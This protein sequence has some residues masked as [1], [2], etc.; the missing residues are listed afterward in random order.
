MIDRKRE[1]DAMD[2]QREQWLQHTSLERGNPARVYRG[3][4]FN[5]RNCSESFNT[6][7]TRMLPSAK[8]PDRV[9]PVTN[10]S[11]FGPRHCG[12]VSAVSAVLPS[13]PRDR[14][15]A[16]KITVRRFVVFG[17]IPIVNLKIL[18]YTNLENA[19]DAI[20]C[21]SFCRPLS[22][23]V[24]YP[25]S[26]YRQPPSPACTLRGTSHAPSGRKGMHVQIFASHRK[27]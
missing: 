14:I 4:S 17:V 16:N 6:P 5:P 21:I 18:C 27:P 2:R 22:R 20:F 15:T 11:R 26:S 10:L 1:T 19:L 12:Q 24:V 25:V 7:R 9:G 8:L 3:P 23:R 13:W